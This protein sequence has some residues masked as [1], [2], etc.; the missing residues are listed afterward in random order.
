MKS[1]AKIKEW[2]GSRKS[3]SKKRYEE[4][5]REFEMAMGKPFII[6]K[7]EIPKG[8]EDQR[9]QFLNLEKDE[10]FLE[11]IRDLI[12][13]RLTYEKRGVKPT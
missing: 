4:E 12:K 6:I 9:A 11:E 13:K 2:F 7:I 1:L 8:F 5:K 3:K 10:D